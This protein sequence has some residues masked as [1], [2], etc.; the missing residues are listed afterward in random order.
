MIGEIF[1]LRGRDSLRILEKRWREYSGG[2][3]VARRAN[4]LP[5]WAHTA[6]MQSQNGQHRGESCL[7]CRNTELLEQ[8]GRVMQWVEDLTQSLI[9]LHVGP[10]SYLE[11]EMQL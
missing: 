1:N 9:E 8:P 11:G 7:P 5:V 4:V 10:C 6:L 2:N 3:A